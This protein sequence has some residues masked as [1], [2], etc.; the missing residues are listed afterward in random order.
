MSLLKLQFRSAEFRVLFEI[1]ASVKKN[2]DNSVYDMIMMMV[3][4]MTIPWHT[5]QEI[6][7]FQFV[8]T[9][10]QNP[11]TW[12]SCSIC[13]S[14]R[15]LRLRS[16]LVLFHRVYLPLLSR[17]FLSVFLTY[18]YMHFRPTSLHACFMSLPY[19]PSW[20]GHRS[21]Y[22]VFCCIQMLS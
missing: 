3:T 4:M 8:L 12:T 20:F 18:L 5:E 16:I 1:Y 7:G 21:T 10:W 14:P 17:L 6:V 15:M 19:D 11:N 22:P 9:R 2:D 13:T